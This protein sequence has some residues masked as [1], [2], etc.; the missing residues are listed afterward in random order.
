MVNAGSFQAN[1]RYW[2]LLRPEIC[3]PVYEYAVV[4]NFTFGENGRR[5]KKAAASPR[6]YLHS[7]SSMRMRKVARLVMEDS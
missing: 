2:N 5:C 4:R 7:H 1:E 6:W 3:R